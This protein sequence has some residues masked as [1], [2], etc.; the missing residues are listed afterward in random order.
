MRTKRRLLR[1]PAEQ[2]RVAAL[3]PY[4]LLALARELDEQLVRFV[5]RELVGLGAFA[6]VDAFRVLTRLVQ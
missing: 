2:V 1:P 4:D 5:L 3:E 6:D